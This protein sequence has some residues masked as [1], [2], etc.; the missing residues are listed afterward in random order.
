[1][2]MNQ[3]NGTQS[4]S[5]SRV[6]ASGLHALKTVLTGSSA[7]PKL[8]FTPPFIL[9]P[10][11]ASD[12]SYSVLR[13]RLLRPTT[14]EWRC[15]ARAAE[16]NL[17]KLAKLCGVSPRSLQRHFPASMGT[18]PQ[19]WLDAER[20]RLAGELL[21]KGFGVLEARNELGFKSSAHF[22]RLF[23]Q[24]YGH[25]PREHARSIRIAAG[26]ADCRQ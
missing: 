11:L 10:S 7:N 8:P 15:L 18:S 13:A 4:C 21:A 14:E 12:G 24:C 5:E 3:H 19:R 23:K 16:Y 6:S 9:N 25:A 26:K 22:S 17:G 2:E 20:M 1:M